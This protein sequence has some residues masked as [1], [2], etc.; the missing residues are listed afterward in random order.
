MAAYSASLRGA[1]RIFIVDRVKERLEMAEKNVRGCVGVDFGK[2][3]DAVEEVMKLNGGGMV[4]RS[5]D[6][7]G[8]QASG[9]EE[10][11]GEVPNSVLEWCI[12]VTRPTGGVGV[13]GLYVPSDPG[14]VDEKVIL[15]PFCLLGRCSDGRM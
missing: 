8:Y 15:P 3:A 1:S 11:E 13:P 7:V 4:D 12:R 6:C 9:K 10:G 2:V 14:A 5:V